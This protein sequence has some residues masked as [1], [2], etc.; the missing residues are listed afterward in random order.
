VIGL[1]VSYEKVALQTEKYQSKKFRLTKKESAMT[2]RKLL[3][4]KLNL[5]NQTINPLTGNIG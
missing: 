1:L 5:T 2:M 4:R 3:N